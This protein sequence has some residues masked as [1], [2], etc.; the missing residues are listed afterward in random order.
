MSELHIALT[1]HR[2]NKLGGYNLNTPEYDA[3]QK[4]FEQYIRV[5]ARKYDVI[6]GHTGLALGGDSIWGKAILAMKKELPEQVKLYA[7][8]PFM[9]Q[10]D[11]WFKQ[12]DKDLWQELIDNADDITVYDPDMVEYKKS[13]T[14][15]ENKGRAAQYLQVRNV[16]M[17]EHADILLALYNGDATGG[18]ANAVHYAQKINKP[19]TIVNPNK[20]FK[21]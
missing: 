19:I 1:G 6:W 7:E 16:G 2:P 5:M 18:T 14:D 12:S 20:Y 17:I 21:N 15:R 8:C 9:N 10:S 13:H 11:V 3:L 4:D